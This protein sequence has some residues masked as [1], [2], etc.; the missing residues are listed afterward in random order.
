VALLNPPRAAFCLT[1]SFSLLPVACP[2]ALSE[3]TR[4]VCRSDFRLRVLPVHSTKSLQPSGG[5][6]RFFRLDTYTS[7]CRQSGRLPR[8][9]DSRASEPCCEAPQSSATPS[10]GHS[11]TLRCSPSGLP[12]R[13]LGPTGF[14][15]PDSPLTWP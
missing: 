12:S 7:R 2:S 10:L 6:P 5:A 8:T 9:Q 14:W 3:L 1:S 4:W 15:L 11:Q 13:G